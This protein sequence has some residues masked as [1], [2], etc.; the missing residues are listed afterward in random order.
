[1][2]DRYKYF[3]FEEEFKDKMEFFTIADPNGSNIVR[4]SLFFKTP[5]QTSEHIIEKEDIRKDITNK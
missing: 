5:I 2:N 4:G 3:K 1:M